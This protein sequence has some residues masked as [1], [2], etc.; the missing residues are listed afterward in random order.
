[1]PGKVHILCLIL[2]R[3]RYI[4]AYCQVREKG[5]HLGCTHFFWMAI[6]IETNELLNPFAIDPLGADG[7]VFEANLIT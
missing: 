4:A 2:R 6:V 1:M 5:F 7:V 3:R